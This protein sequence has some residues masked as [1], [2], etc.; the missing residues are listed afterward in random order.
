MTLA[1]LF[2]IAECTERRKQ[3]FGRAYDDVVAK[4]G[5]PLRLV[6]AR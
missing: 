5:T 4:L 2:A 6:K 1:A 3:A